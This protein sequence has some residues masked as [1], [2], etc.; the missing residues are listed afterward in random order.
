MDVRMDTKYLIRKVLF[1]ITGFLVG[2]VP[3]KKNLVLFTAWRGEK[4]IDNTRYVYEYLLTNSS[5]N[6]VWMTNNTRIYNTLNEEHKPV[7][8]FNSL[9]GVLLQIRAEAVFSTIQFADYNCWLLSRCIYIDL[10]HGHPIKDPGSDIISKRSRELQKLVT[11]K[12]DYYAVVASTKTKRNYTVVDIAKDNIYISDFAR[13]DVLFDKK[14]QIGKNTIVDSFKKGRKA[15]VYMPTQ[16]SAGNKQMKMD[17]ILPLNDIQKFCEQNNI[18]FIIKKHF[19]HR[20][21]IEELSQYSNILDITNVEDIDPQV[22]LCQTD[23]LITDYSACYIDYMLLKRPLIFYHYDIKEFIKTE[24]TLY[25][26]FEKI[27]IA[28]VVYSKQGLVPVM[29]RMINSEDEYLNRRMRFAQEN[30]YDNINHNNACKKI[31]DI[32]DNLMTSNDK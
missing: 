17:V 25:Y 26:D 22:L 29:S 32:L 24:R 27:Q 28:P 15:I 1:R 21:E 23:I 9:R 19:Y 3:K 31:K 20:N 2:L 8:M 5:Y 18:C 6:V 14:L 10:S 30:Y 7:C 12:I 16:R 11:D 4:Y 13:N